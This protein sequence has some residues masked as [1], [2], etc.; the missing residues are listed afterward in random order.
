VWR[1]IR[2]V[3]L[4]LAERNGIS[5]RSRLDISQAGATMSHRKA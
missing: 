4:F 3:T 1:L 5:R 2:D